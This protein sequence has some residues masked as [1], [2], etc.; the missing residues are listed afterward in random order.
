MTST[1][2]WLSLVMNSIHTSTANGSM[3]TPYD[4]RRLVSHDLDKECG[5]ELPSIIGKEGSH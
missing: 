4:V 5:E 3:E 2:S 1:G